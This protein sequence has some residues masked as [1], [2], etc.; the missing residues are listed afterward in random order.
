IFDEIDNEIDRSYTL[1]DIAYTSYSDYE[2]Y[3]T[4]HLLLELIKEDMVLFRRGYHDVIN[5]IN[6]VIYKV[7]NAMRK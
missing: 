4:T 7:S 6:Q 1:F 5:P 2:N 3:F